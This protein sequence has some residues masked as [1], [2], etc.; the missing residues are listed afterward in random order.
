MSEQRWEKTRMTV[1]EFMQ[2]AET[3]QKMELINGELITYGADSMSPAAKDMYE[4]L[5]SVI[6]VY[7]SQ[8]VPA[9]E[10]RVSRT[11]IHI[12]GKNIVQPDILWASSKTAQCIRKED[13]YLHGP[14]DLIVE[15]LSPSTA[16]RDKR[17]KFN[18]YEAS[19]VREYWM[20]EYDAV[21]V[22]VHVLIDEKFER[23]GA[24][25]KD[26]VFTSSV[27]DSTIS[28]NALLGR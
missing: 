13:G 6:M 4:E 16:V 21:L 25:G 27:L 7:L 11:D 8:F 28:V 19:G 12:D 14:P 17:D 24:F 10:L 2:L 26:D 9:R 3:S 1:E 15:V 18:I 23:R 20:V 5:I 22:E